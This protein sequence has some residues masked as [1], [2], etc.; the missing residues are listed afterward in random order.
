MEVG[1]L[2]FCLMMTT[3]QRLPTPKEVVGISYNISKDGCGRDNMAERRPFKGHGRRAD[4]AIIL[5][6]TSAWRMKLSP[7][8]RANT[9]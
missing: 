9:Q 4:G 2:W 8:S 3:P 6:L 1:E 5:T 7:H